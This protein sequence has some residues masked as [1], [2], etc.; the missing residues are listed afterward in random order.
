V[1]GGRAQAETR[2]SRPAATEPGRLVPIAVAAFAVLAVSHGAIFARMA[3]AP[4]LAI[5]AWR[6]TFAAGAVAL[7]LPWQRRALRTRLRPRALAAIGGASACLALHFATWIASLEYTSVSNSVI[8]VNT[9]PIW[10]AL[11][12]RLT[13]TM[14]LSG[15]VLTAVALAVAGAV[16]IAV[17]GGTS[18]GSVR[19]D[20]LALGG[21][22]AIGGYL[23]F[24]RAAR[25][26]VPLVPYL[27]GSYFAA[28]AL[29]WLVAIATRTQ[30]D[31]FSAHT[32]LALVGIAVVPQ[33]IGHS[34]YNWALRFLHP[35]TVSITLLGE[36]IVGS[37]LALIYFGEAIPGATWVGGPLVLAAIWLAA[38]AEQSGR[39]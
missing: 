26:E 23:M 16:I 12:G 17:A 29:L 1:S 3:V 6:L 9:S 20:L 22:A 4:A 8:L 24:A 27:F 39:T 7:A 18:G 5:A 38:R 10:V 34:S 13:G 28:A 32:W 2:S 31:G 36:G 25:L 37:A 33:L 15:S 19:G 14:R 21:G 35:S 11:F 30:M